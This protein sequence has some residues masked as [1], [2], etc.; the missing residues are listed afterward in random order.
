MKVRDYSEDYTIKNLEARKETGKIILTWTYRQGS[1]F[2]ICFH[3]RKKE[4][5]IDGICSILNE[6][7]IKDSAFGSSEALKPVVMQN[8]TQIYFVGRNVYEN[9]RQSSKGYYVDC[10]NLT[11]DIAYGIQVYACN[12]ENGKLTVF[13]PKKDEHRCCIPVSVRCQFQYKDQLFR[14]TK[15]CTMLISKIDGYQD[16][17]VTYRVEGLDG[18]YVPEI[19]V[20]GSILGKKMFIKIPR[21]AEIRVKVAESYKNYFKMA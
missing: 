18:G 6:E 8:Q 14:P 15:I 3:D 11:A 10:K 1:H 12:Y 4:M 21:K 9:L 5:D 13:R 17:A 7:E 16:G 2:L 20:P 19:P